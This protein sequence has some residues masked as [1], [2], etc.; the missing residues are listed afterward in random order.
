MPR[1]MVHTPP[2]SQRGPTLALH[3]V[4]KDMGGP[5]TDEGGIMP[6]A[7]KQR[8]GRKG[9]QT[10]SKDRAHMAAIGR[11][12][13]QRSRVKRSEKQ[14]LEKQDQKEQVGGSQISSRQEHQ[15][16]ARE[17]PRER[18]TSR[19]AIEMLK[20]DHQRVQDLFE[21]YETAGGD[22][23]MSIAH[24]I[25]KELE[26][27]AAIEEEIFYPAF[28]EKA[29]KQGEDMVTEALEEHQAVKT[30]LK[31]LKAMEPEDDTFESTF[32][33]MIHDVMH[34]VTEEEGEMLP[35][36]EEVLGPALEELGTEMERRKHDLMESLETEAL[37]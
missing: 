28:K 24:K 32:H 16:E 1:H 4:H 9:G 7:K 18:E 11:K 10:V 31:E 35:L 37:H 34:H 36:A 26:I 20:N 2:S 29:G 22:D 13:G 19:E 8:A 17:Q 23:K 30:A 12:G 6:D 33:D 27:H 15:Q 25:M 14:D 3:D 5:Q 21:Q